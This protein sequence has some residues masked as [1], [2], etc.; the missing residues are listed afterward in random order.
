MKYYDHKIVFTSDLKT[1]K[2][3]AIEL[4]HGMYL[5]C[6]PKDIIS[7]CYK[8][9]GD[10]GYQLYINTEATGVRYKEEGDIQRFIRKIHNYIML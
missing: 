2:R 3:I 10:I 6:S 4:N 8:D 5:F 1:E 9:E 7:L